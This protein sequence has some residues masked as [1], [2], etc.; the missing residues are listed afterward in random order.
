MSSGESRDA[1]TNGYAI[2]LAKI[3]KALRSRWYYIVGCAL[4]GAVVALGSSLLATPMYQAVSTLYVT[5]AVDADA[6]TAYQGSL[7]SQ[8]RVMSYEQLATSDVVV[9]RALREHPSLDF[10]VEE[11]TAALS[12]KASSD[13]VL[14]RLNAV[15]DNSQTSV[16]LVDAVSDALVN[17][18]VGLETPAAGGT[19]LAKLTVVS[20][21]QAL[22]K[23]VSPKTIRN[24][25]VGFVA[26]ALVGVVILLM[27]VRFDS[28]V[29]S[30]EEA[31]D[32]VGVVSLGG[33]PVDDHIQSDSYVNFA[34]GSSPA[35]EAFRS[36]R[37]NIE[38]ASVDRLNRKIL[39]TS[40]CPGD[41]KTT[42]ALSIAASLA[43]AGKRV[44]LVDG[45]LRNPNVAARC[46]L[47]TD[48]GFTNALRGD[49][50][51]Q[52]LVQQ[53]G[54]EGLDVLASGARPPNPAELLG[55]SRASEVIDS[56][57]Q[58]YDHVIIDSP[59]VLP[60]TDGA[61]IAQYVDGVLLVA[62]VGQTSRSDLAK[63]ADR[64]L[65]AKA[66]LLGLV[67]NAEDVQAGYYQYGHYGV[68]S[69]S[70]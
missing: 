28:V 18:V 37:T 53:S 10:T 46:G 39:V 22:S 25:S 61:V 64:L 70:T 63:G 17:Y 23:P 24:I 12:A 33:I 69:S 34:G 58:N 7:A 27:A 42:V 36:L 5:S 16:Q 3:A 45:D 48:V 30:E 35:A 38:F 32:A 59:P 40:A 43:E 13:T 21:G 9:A 68:E 55:T 15:T 8:Q 20:Q 4:V 29:R 52:M 65:T 19:P 60:V 41:G 31:V 14:L 66:P 1:A 54:L 44:V 49:A 6:L 57:A 51:L 26:G 62:R 50:E 67:V 56:L 47:N 11:A 2:S